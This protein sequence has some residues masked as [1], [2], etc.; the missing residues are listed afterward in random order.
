MRAALVLVALLVCAPVAHA[1]ALGSLSGATIAVDPGHNGRNWARP[2]RIN[3][4][5]DAGTLWKPCDTTGTATAGGYTEAAFNWDV[6][7]RL[8][9]IL[10]RA[11]ATVVLSRASNA[12]WGPCITERAAFG[13]RVEA[14]AA[15][16]IH[17]D[18]STPRGRGFHVIYPPAI[19]GLTD[20]IARASYRL[21]LALRAAYAETTG[22]PYATYTGDDGLSARSD[23]GGLNLSDVPKVFLEAGNMRNSTDARL[24]TSPSFRRR[25]A[26]GIAL[27]LAE[28]LADPGRG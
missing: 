24:L 22:M 19:A 20:D 25:A 4:L 12:G 23:L 15:I 21:A 13:N 8:R 2:E 14:D 9:R 16:S 1:G 17:A 3:R 10:E 6:A 5:V 26:R 27:G 18:G 11:G 7:R 28:F